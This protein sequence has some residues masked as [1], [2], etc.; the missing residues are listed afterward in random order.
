MENLLNV[1]SLPRVAV[2]A[3]EYS[4]FLPACYTLTYDSW[5]TNHQIF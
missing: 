3:L 5:I 2:I 1:V 4:N